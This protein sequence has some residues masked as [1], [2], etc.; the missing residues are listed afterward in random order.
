MRFGVD[1]TGWLN[2]RGFGRFT[3]NAVTRLVETDLEAEYVLLAD[4]ITAE[5][6]LPTRATIRLL[7]TRLPPAE[8]AG[9]GS[10]R[11]VTD[12]L[13]VVRAA[14]AEGLDALL[15]PSLHTWFPFAGTPTV[16][17]VHD[18]IADD[19]PELALP[20]RRD[21][22]L[23]QLKQRL[24][25]RSARRVF[26][27]SEA[28]RSRVVI[29]FG[30][31]G[32]GVPVVPEAPD[33]VFSPRPADEVAEARVAIGAPERYLLFAGGISPHKNVT[34]LVDAYAELVAHVPDPPALVV[35][36]ALEEETFASSAAAVRER[37][38]RRGLDGRVL[39][40]GF[41][42]D[43][44]LARLYAGALAFVSPSL[45]EGFGLPAV[46]AAACG[47]PLVLSDLPAH[48]ESMGDAALYVAPGDD[49]ALAEAL[50]RLLKDEGLRA[51]LAVN[52][53]ERVAMRTWDAA[54][55]ALAELL[56][57]AA[58]R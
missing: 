12:V 52:G 53:R 51:S 42:S 2:R 30:L 8:A 45:A 31:A 58:L 17:G 16:V 39:L 37:I 36:G 25:V 56:R 18:T 34:G 22:A 49:A 10:R 4:P 26:A 55:G 50:L 35:V 38:A 14:R 32:N 20:R 13:R 28:S 54:A 21:R 5:A 48:R 9:A 23:W 57:E 40:P 41:V 27:V 47:A 3:R 29:R 11:G 44:I 1:A 15:F 6:G 7:N 43:E 19:L 46:E 24:A 33:P